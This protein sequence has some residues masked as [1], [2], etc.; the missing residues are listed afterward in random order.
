MVRRG[1]AVIAATGGFGVASIAKAATSAIPIIFI[2][3]EDPVRLGLVASL[4][5]PG[6]NLT[7]VN[8]LATELAAKRLDLL[9]ELVPGATRIAVLVNPAD[10]ANTEPT[11]ARC[12]RGCS[13]RRTSSSGRPCKLSGFLSE[14]RTRQM[15]RRALPSACGDRHGHEMRGVAGFDAHQ[16]RVLAR[17]ARLL[18]GLAHV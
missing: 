10:A 17:R 4:A 1:V 7:G 5:R 12:R 9:R 6:G 2:V 3:A 15:R 18:E 16:D 8:F 14:A 11:F 13:H